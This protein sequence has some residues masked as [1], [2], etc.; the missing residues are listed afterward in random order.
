M[1]AVQNLMAMA[2][3]IL[4]TLLVQRFGTTEWVAYVR[5]AQRIMNVPSMFMQGIS[6]TTLPVFSRYAG[7][8]DLLRMCR[9]YFR[10]SLYSGLLITTGILCSLPF[11]PW[12][13]ER[14]F[15]PDYHEPVWRVCRILVPGFALMS[16]AIANDTFYLVTDTLRVG[17][18]LSVAGTV[19]NTAVIA[20]LTSRYPTVGVAWGLDLTMTLS[21][22]HNAYA[23][24]WYRKHRPELLARASARP[25]DPSG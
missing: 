5:I 2:T 14:A 9:A 18:L 21:L 22:M 23:W 4:P 20:F 3:Q 11:L 1:G 7:Q 15:P 12:V 19:V 25:P 16:F 8:G 17:I 13:I 24:I 10:A 6:R